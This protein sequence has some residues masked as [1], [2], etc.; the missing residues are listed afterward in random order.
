ME[1]STFSKVLVFKVNSLDDSLKRGNQTYVDPLTTE[2]LNAEHPRVFATSNIWKA[3]CHPPLPFH[4]SLHLK[5]LSLSP[6]FLVSSRHSQM[7]E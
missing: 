1:R 4:A 2:L 6:P 7:M 5:S 3:F